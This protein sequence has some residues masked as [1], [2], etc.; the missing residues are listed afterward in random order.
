[1]IKYLILTTA[2]LFSTLLY[3]QHEGRNSEGHEK[4]GPVLEII[5]S[6]IHAFSLKDDESSYGTEI[7]LTY[8]ATHEWGGGLSYTA[9]FEEEETLHDI[10]LLGSWNVTRWMTLN[11]GPN[12]GFSGEE[13]D[14]EVSAYAEAEGNIRLSEWFHFG[15]VTGVILGENSE[16]IVGMH[17]GFEF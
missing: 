6:G 3:G 16:I 11:V 10:A 9:K 13:R 2:F 15:P 8:W 4:E 12:F 1:M 5:T 7:H 14:F 17:L